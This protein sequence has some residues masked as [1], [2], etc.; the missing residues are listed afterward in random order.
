[1]KYA[2]GIFSNITNR[3]QAEEAL[4]D[5]EEKYRSMMESIDDLVYIC[6]PDYHVEYMNPAM[7]KR[8]GRNAIGEFCF[9]VI[10]GLDDECPW[11]VYDK[12]E[13]GENCVTEIVSP[14]DGRIYNVSHSRLHHVDDSISKLAI[15]RDIT[16]IRN[17][18]QQLQQASKMESIGTL[19]GGVAHEFNNSLMGIM[20]HIELLKMNL[21]EDEGTNKSLDTMN[22]A[23]QRMSRLTDQLL[24][25]AEGGK[26]QPKNLKLGR[27]CDRNTAN[28][29]T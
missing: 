12:V 1:M 14:K 9:K 8:T 20:G 4:R 2:D 17:M 5:S 19:A 21:S 24:A 11:C 6:S 23:G 27:F 22:T 3:K 13:Q 29:A 25:Y 7:V 15:Y 26:Y 18:E 16:E 28:S 10:N